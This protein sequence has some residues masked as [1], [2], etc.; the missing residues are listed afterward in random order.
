MTRIGVGAEVYG[1]V[2]FDRDG[3]AADTV[4]VPADQIAAKPRS[5]SPPEAAALPLPAL[6][7]QQSLFEYAKIVAG[8]R[9][10]ILGG[11]G[12]VGG[13]AVQMAAAAG[14]HVTA[15]TVGAI[16]YVRGLGADEVVDVRTGDFTTLIPPVD[17]IIDTVSGDTLNRSYGLIRRGGR[18]VTLQTPPDR[19]K[20]KQFGVTAM[21]F[22]VHTDTAALNRL[23][24][25]V[26]T[27]GLRVTIAATFALADGQA[28][29][30]SG[31]ASGRA[32][33]KTALT[34]TPRRR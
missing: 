16:D 7:A 1:P 10:L 20:A 29:Y 18:L 27:R 12:G 11:A 17:C 8:E 3:A 32:P 4:A 31:A 14:A 34:V 13:H 25:L 22:V 19:Q 26:D 9:V 24:D 28:A 21:F 15:T 33:G 30:A 6:T 5:L 2:P 23:A